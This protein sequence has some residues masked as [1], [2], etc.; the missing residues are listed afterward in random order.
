LRQLAGTIRQAAGGAVPISPRAHL[1]KTAERFEC[2]DQNATGT[3]LVISHHVQALVHAIDEIDIRPP[4]GA[5][6]NFGA[7][8]QTARGMGR[9]IINAEVGLRF[10]DSSSGFVMHQNA[11]QQCWCEFDRRTFEELQSKPLRLFEEHAEN[12]R[13]VK[14]TIRKHRVWLCRLPERI[15]TLCALNE[16]SFRGYKLEH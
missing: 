9:E 2:P 4:G 5:E 15:R 16:T 7:L 1:F 10:D 11:A 8:G 12:G 13:G 3:A 14:R 6:Q